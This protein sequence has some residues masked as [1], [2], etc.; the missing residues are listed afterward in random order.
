MDQK[1]TRSRDVSYRDKTREISH[2]F[3]LTIH[4]TFIG[5]AGNGGKLM[6][7][8]RNLPKY[9]VLIMK[10]GDHTTEIGDF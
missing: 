9:T 3:I 7:A 2:R 6:I 5:N 8:L 10:V 4:Y 1:L